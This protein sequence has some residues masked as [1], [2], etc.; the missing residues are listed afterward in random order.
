[1]SLIN[2]CSA[3]QAKRKKYVGLASSTHETA[4]LSVNAADIQSLVGPLTDVVGLYNVYISEKIPVQHIDTINV[5]A[6]ADQLKIIK[7][8]F[9]QSPERSVLVKNNDWPALLNSIKAITKTIRENCQSGWTSFSESYYSSDSLQTLDIVKTKSNLT[10]LAEYSLLVN[11]LRI[12]AKSGNDIVS[13][14]NFK[15]K[16]KRLKEI[17]KQLMDIKAPEDVK[18]F[19]TAINGGG[20]SLDLLTDEVAN[21]LKEQGI[22]TK[23]KIVGGL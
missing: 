21:W 10:L 1:M 6:T 18:K 2:R 17:S 22:Y 7:D 14:Q 3:L 20:A 4:S 23:Y 19:L 5:T 12:L 11:E 15:K 9:N 8:R 13:I 16:G